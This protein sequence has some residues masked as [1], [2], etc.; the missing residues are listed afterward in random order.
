VS[1]EKGVEDFLKLDLAGTKIIVGDGPA[2]ADLERRYPHVRFLG[3]R[4]GLALTEAYAQADLFVFPS[5]TDTFGLVVVEALACGLPVAAYPATGPVDIITHPSLGATHENLKIAIS[6][7]LQ[8]GVRESCLAEAAKF[9]WEA[10][11]RQFEQNLA[12]LLG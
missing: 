3:Y 11:T 6:T 1:T 12:P 8:T 4:T 7:A 10:C 2:R 5:K 9:T